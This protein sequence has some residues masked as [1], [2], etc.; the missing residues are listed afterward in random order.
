V[1]DTRKD[2]EKGVQ[3]F[4]T[5]NYLMEQILIELARVPVRAGKREDLEPFILF[6]DP[7]NGMSIQ[8]KRQGEA[9][10]T[11]FVGHKFVKRDYEISEEILRSVYCLDD[12]IF[13]PT[14]DELKEWYAG[15]ESINQEQEEEKSE[16]SIRR[17]H[18]SEDETEP[19]KKQ[20]RESRSGRHY[21]EDET[22]SEVEESDQKPLKL[23]RKVMVDEEEMKSKKTGLVCPVKNGKFGVDTD[24]LP[25]CD[26]CRIWKECVKAQN[27]IE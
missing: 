2:E 14:Y 3:V 1:Y 23:K 4:H 12:L 11:R 27:N 22:E 21:L 26:S 15:V 24:T 20:E 5:S 10:N 9:Q 6:A 18:L 16:H 19:N 25:E 8:F 17:R 13:V 7:K